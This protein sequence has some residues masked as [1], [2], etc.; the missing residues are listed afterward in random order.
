M[1]DAGAVFEKAH[2]DD[3]RA[4]AAFAA[5]VLRGMKNFLVGQAHGA[6]QAIGRLAHAFDLRTENSQRW[7]CLRV[8]AMRQHSFGSHAAGAFAGLQ[9]A[10]AV[11]ED[12]QVQL[13][14][15]PKAVFVIFANTPF[16][17]ARA[18]FH[19]T[20]SALDSKWSAAPRICA[21]PARD[22]FVAGEN[23]SV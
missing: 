21:C 11:R 10:H 18:Y 8:A 9:A 12:E 7:V 19:R 2:G 17:A 23:A 13:R 14:R 16:I 22:W 6:G 5:Y 20:S 1:R 4:H 3:G 15:E